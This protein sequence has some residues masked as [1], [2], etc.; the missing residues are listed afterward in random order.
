MN[1]ALGC[2]NLCS[3]VVITPPKSA[4]KRILFK[5][6]PSDENS[7]GSLGHLT[8]L[9]SSSP[10]RY[11]SPPPSPQWL[12]ETPPRKCEF[13]RSPLGPVQ[14]NAESRKSPRIFCV[15]LHASSVQKLPP[16]ETQEDS[17][18]QNE[19]TMDP[20]TDV[21]LIKESP[22]KGPSNMGLMTPFKR[23]ADKEKEDEVTPKLNSQKL[24]I[25]ESPDIFSAAA[26]IKMLQKGKPDDEAGTVLRPSHAPTGVCKLSSLPT[27]FFYHTTR[28]RAELFPEHFSK[29]KN[30]VS[31]V[32][33]SKKRKRSV[34]AESHSRICF[35]LF[36]PRSKGVKRYKY[37]EINAGVRHSI[38]K[39][40]KKLMYKYPVDT[41]QPKIRPEDRIDSYLNK[42]EGSNTG[43]KD[44]DK[45]R[46][47]HITPSH[48]IQAH[49]SDNSLKSLDVPLMSDG[50]ELIPPSS[51]VL[52]PSKKFFKT[53]RTLKINSNA[54][55]TVDK[56]IKLVPFTV[57]IIFYSLIKFVNMKNVLLYLSH[58]EL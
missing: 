37:G 6:S 47:A 38:K 40:R 17:R 55:V 9:N 2:R 12:V 7:D 46:D 1:G 39:Y 52:D 29:S 57:L 30:T 10:D 26:P 5:R 24:V 27:S 22:M 53:Q 20:V 31:S 28:A 16:N 13:S 35:S 4:R 15:D 42:F 36:R 41:A 49:S 18:G 11:S 3:G 25:G 48:S 19:R 33:N 34:N 14:R 58:Y 8:P 44:F 51:P 32:L 43:T 54:T 21:E 56:N 45:G 23:L 50:M